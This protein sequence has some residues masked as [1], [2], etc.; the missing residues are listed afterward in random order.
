MCKDNYTFSHC[1]SPFLLSSSLSPLPAWLCLAH[2]VVQNQLRFV[3]RLNGNPYTVLIYSGATRLFIRKSLV[4]SSGR[5]IL[6]LAS[7]LPLYAFDSATEPRCLLTE[8]TTWLFELPNFHRFKW[9]VLVVDST[10]M[11][12]TILGY[13]FL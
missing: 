10:D 7:S 13:D 4:T 8:R 5:Y 6:P 12:D 11:D 9:Q 1:T 3:F 2:A